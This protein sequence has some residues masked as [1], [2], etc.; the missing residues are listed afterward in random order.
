MTSSRVHMRK[1][2][3]K[4]EKWIKATAENVGKTRNLICNSLCLNTALVPSGSTCWAHFVAP[5][6]KLQSHLFRFMII[7]LFRNKA[8]VDTSKSRWDQNGL[9]CSQAI[10]Y[11]R[12]EIMWTQAQRERGAK[13]GKMQV[14]AKNGLRAMGGATKYGD[15]D[16]SQWFQMGHS[17]ADI[18]V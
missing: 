7:A 16:P 12:Q 6:Y 4:S 5:N 17:P 15:W 10:G 9:E 11:Y 18:L 8:F 13:N 2:Y 3:L 14:K 1:L